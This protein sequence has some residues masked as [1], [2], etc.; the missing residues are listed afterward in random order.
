MS[1]VEEKH[2]SGLR[3]ALR[4]IIW[5]TVRGKGKT[6]MPIPLIFGCARH[7]KAKPVFAMQRD[8]NGLKNLKKASDE[9]EVK[10]KSG[11]SLEVFR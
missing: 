7:D 4:G 5:G 8:T 2:K 1:G 9:A 11:R 3:T 10:Q 6:R